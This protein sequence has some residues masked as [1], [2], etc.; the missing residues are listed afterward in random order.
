[1]AAYAPTCTGWCHGLSENRM[2]GYLIGLRRAGGQAATTAWG[3]SR[4]IP[5]CRGVASA[6]PQISGGRFSPF[7]NARRPSLSGLVVVIDAHSSIFSTNHLE[8]P[9]A[10]TAQ[11]RRVGG[12]GRGDVPVDVRRRARS[13]PAPTTTTAEPAES[14]TR[15]PSSG[16][17]DSINVLFSMLRDGTIPEPRTPNPEPHASLDEGRRGTPRFTNLVQAVLTVHL[18]CST[19]VDHGS[20]VRRVRRRTRQPRGASMQGS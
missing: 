11:V 16:S 19:K 20:R 10:V 15:K 13:R 5:I 18:T 6:V 17:P 14:P 1:M 12:R 8:K 3:D 4:P 7:W 2:V 9:C